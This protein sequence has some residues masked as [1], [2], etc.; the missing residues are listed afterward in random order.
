MRLLGNG[1]GVLRVKSKPVHYD[2]HNLQPLCHCAQAWN[3]S[4]VAIFQASCLLSRDYTKDN[5]LPTSPHASVLPIG[6]TTSYPTTSRTMRRCSAVRGCSYIRVFIAGKTYVG[7]V[8]ESART[9]EVFGFLEAGSAGSTTDSLQDCRM[10]RAQS[11]IEYS[12][13][14]ALRARCLLCPTAELNMQNRVANGVVLLRARSE[15]SSLT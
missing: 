8:G 7:V 11:L 9:R 14:M 3:R 13:N 10:L 5:D 12:R 1:C 2:L 4:S 6:P 15:Y